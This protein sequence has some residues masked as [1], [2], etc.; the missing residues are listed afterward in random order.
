MSFV[1][2]GKPTRMVFGWHG[3]EIVMC[4]WLQAHREGC[5]MVDMDENIMCRWRQK[6]EI[7]AV[8]DWRW[9]MG[10]SYEADGKVCPSGIWMAMDHCVFLHGQR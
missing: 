6:D 1:A 8:S 9:I 5:C 7:G 10:M 2:G 3:P 4:G